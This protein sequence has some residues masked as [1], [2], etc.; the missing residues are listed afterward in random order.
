MIDHDTAFQVAENL[1][2]ALVEEM[3]R[4]L[5]EFVSL[6]AARITEGKDDV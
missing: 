6:E 3:L 4:A 2:R 5:F 1:P